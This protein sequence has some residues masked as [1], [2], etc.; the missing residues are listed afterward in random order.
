MRATCTD[1]L[2]R[3]SGIEPGARIADVFQL[4]EKVDITYTMFSR[5][6]AK[7]SLQGYPVMVDRHIPREGTNA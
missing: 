7:M 6:Y 5:K 3:I 4:T 2:T 1:Q